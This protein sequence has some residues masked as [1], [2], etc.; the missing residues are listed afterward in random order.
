MKTSFPKM[1]GFLR[2][3]SMVNS[4]D[5]IGENPEVLSVLLRKS[6]AIFRCDQIVTNRILMLIIIKVY[7]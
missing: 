7:T 5:R 1:V 3:M 4:Y 2:F 6:Y